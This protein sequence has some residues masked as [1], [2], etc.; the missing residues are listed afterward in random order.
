MDGRSPVPIG[1]FGK[2]LDLVSGCVL[3]GPPAGASMT[4]RANAG[5]PAKTVEMTKA[6]GY[7][8]RADA[9]GR[10]LQARNRSERVPL[11]RKQ[12]ALSDLADNEDWLDGKPMPAAKSRTK[13]QR[14]EHSDR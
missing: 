4:H 12:K 9:V 11:L 13:G 7:R 5:P 2:R 14:E 8:K 6:E 1:W 3:A 10:G